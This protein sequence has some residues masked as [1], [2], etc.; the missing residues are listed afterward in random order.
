MVVTRSAPG[1]KQE[2]PLAK[3]IDQAYQH[4][5]DKQKEMFKRVMKDR[6]EQYKQMDKTERTHFKAQV[7]KRISNSGKR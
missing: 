7:I 2:N 1:K 6:A 5:S 3:K 4:M